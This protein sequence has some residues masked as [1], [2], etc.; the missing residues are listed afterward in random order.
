MGEL[1]PLRGGT[2]AELSSEEPEALLSLVTAG[3]LSSAV[4]S[5]LQNPLPA[6]KSSQGLSWEGKVLGAAGRGEGEQLSS[7]KKTE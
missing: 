3:A 5:P 1:Q 6:L 2:V 4:S 7:R